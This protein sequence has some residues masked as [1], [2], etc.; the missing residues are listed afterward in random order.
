MLRV[1]KWPPVWEVL[2]D[3]SFQDPRKHPKTS[4]NWKWTLL[5]GREWPDQMKLCLV[6]NKECH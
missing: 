3:L 4:A 6:L 1:G 5:S 2:S